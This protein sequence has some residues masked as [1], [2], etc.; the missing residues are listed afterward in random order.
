M[1]YCVDHPEREASGMCVLCGKPFCEECLLQ[2]DGKMHCKQCAQE[3]FYTLGQVPVPLWLSLP[4]L[5]SPAE[6]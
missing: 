1:I 6:L 3:L 4:H 5:R 2:L